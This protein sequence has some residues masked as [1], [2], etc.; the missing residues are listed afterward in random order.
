MRFSSLAVLAVAAAS[1]SASLVS[2]QLPSCAL[3]CISGPNVDLGGCAANDNACLCKS[4]TF[5][6]KSTACITS[7]CKGAE[8]QQALSLAQQLCAAVGVTLSG[9][10]TGAPTATAT[11]PGGSGN[12]TVTSHSG[13]SGSTSTAPPTQT[14]NSAR[15]NTAGALAGM[16]AF[17]LAALA[18]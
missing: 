8:L 17:G 7:S 4:Q 11:S 6:E 9:T 15:S 12:S 5:V 16:A 14:S 3:S 18:L 1:A 2:R 13:A 10:P